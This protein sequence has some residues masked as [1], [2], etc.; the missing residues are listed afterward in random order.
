[1]AISPVVEILD[2]ISGWRSQFLDT[3]FWGDLQNHSAERPYNSIIDSE[4]CL[5]FLL[6]QVGLDNLKLS[7]SNSGKDIGALSDFYERLKGD[8]APTKSKVRLRIAERLV[9]YFERHLRDP[10]DAES[11]QLFDS[12]DYMIFEDGFEK[13]KGRFVSIDAYALSLS[14][15]LYA[16][17]YALRQLEEREGATPDPIWEK[18]VDL[19]HRRITGS[20]KGLLSGFAIFQLEEDEFEHMSGRSWPFQKWIDP[21][22]SEQQ[23]RQRNNCLKTLREVK[24]AL[25]A[26]GYEIDSSE[27]TPFECGWSWGP[28]SDSGILPKARFSGGSTENMDEQV[29]NSVLESIA[30]I[31]LRA[32]A[33]PY[34]YFTVN[35]IDSIDDLNSDFIDDYNLL[36]SEQMQFAGKLVRLR[37]LAVDYWYAMSTMPAA[38]TEKVGWQ[39]ETVPWYTTAG[40]SSHYFNLYLARIALG[41]KNTSEVDVRRVTSFIARLAE[42]AR[43]TS[44]PNRVLSDGKMVVDDTNLRELH[45]PGMKIELT[46][47]ADSSEKIGK[48][49][50]W[51]WSKKAKAIVKRGGTPD[52]NCLLVLHRAR[53]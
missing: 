31:N 52:K 39:L 25:K 48:L 23:I 2:V 42:I 1:M 5:A 16:K 40:D 34:L 12:T 8:G 18:L 21:N 11:D 20:L 15:S 41:R 46:G 43:V 44:P 51:W 30:N 26:V 4:I 10:E 13:P 35:A 49:L 47:R 53:V 28:I 19:S 9:E 27:G 29:R 50:G 32:E 37:G 24:T 6:T 36:D 22:W 3:G 17:I 33:A 38:S 45:N 14:A 7:P